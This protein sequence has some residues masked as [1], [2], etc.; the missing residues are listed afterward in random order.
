MLRILFAWELGSGLGHI[1]PLRAIGRE[2]VKRGH[3]VAIATVQENIE[4]CRHALVGAGIELYCVPTLAPSEHQL[5]TPC[6]Y[7]DLLFGCGYSSP[8]AVTQAVGHWLTLFHRFRPDLLVADHS[9]TALLASKVRR[10]ATVTMGTGFVTP[11]DVAPLPSLRRDLP[12]PPWREEIEQVVLASMNAA[13]SRQGTAGLSR[14]G[15]LFADIEASFLLCPRELDPYSLWRVPESTEY[16]PP[17]GGLPGVACEWPTADAVH[18]G[19]PRIFVYLRDRDVE[20]PLLRGLALK[21]IP[22]VAYSA[23]LSRGER[24]TFI[25]STVLVSPNPIDLKPLLTHCDVGVLHGGL[26]I[27]SELLHAGIPMA[28]LP[29]SLEQ[30]LTAERLSLLGVAKAVAPHDLDALG[31]TLEALLENLNY[32]DAA[33]SFASRSPS[34]PDR[35]AAAGLASRMETL[36]SARNS[37]DRHSFTDS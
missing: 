34:P 26:G 2:L 24:E 29:Q 30:Q 6:T 15:E 5:A 36:V 22:T 3:S 18:S 1:G 17:F 13:L 11:P 35:E 12:L 8:A 16:C 32:R 37:V 7:S 21:Q 20:L 28:I 23:R 25:G 19:G 31:S 33:R 14:I 27:V 10:L 4:L 9:P